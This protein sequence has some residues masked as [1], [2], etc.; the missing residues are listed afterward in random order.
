MRE[1]MRRFAHLGAVIDPAY[2][3]GDDRPPKVPWHKTVI[4]ETHVKGISMQH[5]GVPDN[6]RGVPT[7]G[8]RVNR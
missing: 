6:L 8:S 1:T 7:P 5:P 3:W 4:Y 2:T